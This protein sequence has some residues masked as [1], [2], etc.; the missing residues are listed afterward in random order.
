MK[1]KTNILE[2]LTKE[3]LEAIIFT[4]RSTANCIRHLLDS[5]QKYV[6]TRRFSTDNIERFHGSVRHH[7]GSNDHPSVAHCLSAVEK[8]NRTALSLTSMSANT[9]LKTEAVLRK[10]SPT[11]IMQRN[12]RITRRRAKICL[13]KTN[14][15]NLKILKQLTVPPSNINFNRKPLH[16][17]FLICYSL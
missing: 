6:L 9:P 8:I 13:E 3:T 4:S 2:C 16:A 5:G 1:K 14:P 15:A 11:S 12:P 17:L 7:C 10:E